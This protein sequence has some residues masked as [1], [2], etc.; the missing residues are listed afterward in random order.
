VAEDRV[1]VDDLADRGVQA[2]SRPIRQVLCSVEQQR[3]L[4]PHQFAAPNAVRCPPD[5]ADVLSPGCRGCEV[6]GARVEGIEQAQDRLVLDAGEPF[7][8]L[9]GL[10]GGR[11]ILEELLEVA[12]DAGRTQ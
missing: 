4:I 1:V 8:W 2:I 6:W 3:G 10:A 5:G 9:R 7:L 11:K 12:G